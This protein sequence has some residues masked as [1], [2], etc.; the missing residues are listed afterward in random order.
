MLSLYICLFIKHFPKFL[1]L[2]DTNKNQQKYQWNLFFQLKV[3]DPSIIIDSNNKNG[4][5]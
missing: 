2:K 3:F 1:I 4:V 5:T